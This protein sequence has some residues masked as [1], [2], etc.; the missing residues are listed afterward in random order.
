VFVECLPCLGPAAFTEST[1][2]VDLLETDLTL[3]VDRDGLSWNPP[4]QA[5]AFDA[6]VGD[7]FE[8]GNLAEA[9][10]ACLAENVAAT[11][12]ELDQDPPPG[13]GWW[14]LARPVRVLGAGSWDSSGL[15]QRHPRDRGIEESGAGCF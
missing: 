14:F 10:T 12:L 5:I 4:E 11:S 8:L 3:Q 1:G 13:Q 9:T 6:V 7:L 2:S 15:Q